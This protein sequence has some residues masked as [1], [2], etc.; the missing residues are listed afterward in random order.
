MQLDEPARF[1]DVWTMPLGGE[2]SRRRGSPNVFDALERDF[3]L[4]RQEKIEW[5]SPTA[6]RSRVC[7]SIRST[8]TPGKRYP[9]VVQM[10]GGPME[11]DKFGAGP[12][13]VH[14]LLSGADGEGLRRAAGRTI[15]AAPAMATRSYRDV[16]GHYFR[17]MQLDVMSGVDALIQ[18]G[19]ADPDRLVADGLERRRSPRQQADHDDAVGSRPLRPGRAWRT[20]CR[21][22]RRPTRVRTARSWFGGTPWQKDAPIA[23]YWDNSPLKD[24]ANVRTPTLLF[25]GENDARVPMAQSVEMYRALRATACRRRLWIAPRE[26]HQWGELRH[27]L[28]KANIELEWFDKYVMGRSYVWEKAPVDV[29]GIPS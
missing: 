4:P 13:L 6:R 1:G 28:F 20:G 8:T 5:A 26:A 29:V 27:L 10:H 19:I 12:G 21:C 15:A 7:S 14:E 2:Q 18:R 9:L 3:I 22:T 24:V 25:V 17:N 16:V 11:S 23:A